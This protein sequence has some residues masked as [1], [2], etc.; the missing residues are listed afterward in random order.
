MKLRNTS[1][2]SNSLNIF[3]NGF[4]KKKAKRKKKHWCHS[5]SFR[6]KSKTFDAKARRSKCHHC[7]SSFLRERLRS[8]IDCTPDLDFRIGPER[9][10]S[11]LALEKKKKKRRNSLPKTFKKWV[12]SKWNYFLRER[13]SELFVTGEAE[14]ICCRT[15]TWLFG[16]CFTNSKPGNS[17]PQTW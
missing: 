10:C 14:N 3:K 17:K 9:F 1:F 7:I 6:L 2:K 15:K 8:E 12:G 16:G 13:R 5:S 4:C 11:S